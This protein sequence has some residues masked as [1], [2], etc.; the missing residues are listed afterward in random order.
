MEV[1][2]IVAVAKNNWGIGKNNDLLW[3]LPADM[4]FFK[5]TTINFPI[6]T[7]R[8][9]YESIPKKFRPLPQRENIILSNQ[10]NYNAEG[11]YL[12]NSISDAIQSAKSFQKE[13]CFVIGG[14]EI[15]KTFLQQNLIDVMWITWVEG[16][17]D[18]DTFFPKFDF[19]KWE[20]TQEIK[21][22]KDDKNPHN[23]TFAKYQV[24]K[25]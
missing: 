14:G 18:A 19:S 7:G 25:N 16:E 3:R 4:A 17:F 2:L 11:A 21:R 5:K 10:K 15:Y 22:E 9:N 13:K 1:H 20:L 23:I 6:I 12:V 8:K 24:R